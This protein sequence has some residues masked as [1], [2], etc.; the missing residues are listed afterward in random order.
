MKNIKA[1][2][3]SIHQPNFLPYPGFFNKIKNS[4]IFIL[5]DTAQYVKDRW[6]NRNRVRTKEGS[7]YITIPLLNRDS[8]KK[9]FTEIPLPEGKWRNKH[10]LK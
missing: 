10:K 6:D 1:S 5:Y 9:K 7:A 4:D 3:V 8:Y 2:T